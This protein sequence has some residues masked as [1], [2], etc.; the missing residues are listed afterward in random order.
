MLVVQLKRKLKV[1]NNSQLKSHCSLLFEL[2]RSDS[3]LTV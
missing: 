2:Q 3:E 1:K